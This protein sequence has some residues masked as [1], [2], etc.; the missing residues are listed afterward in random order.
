MYPVFVVAFVLAI[1]IGVY[2]LLSSLNLEEIPAKI[3]FIFI[4]IPLTSLVLYLLQ[5]ILSW[6]LI[7][8]NSNVQLRRPFGIKKNYTRQIEYAEIRQIG[9]L[10]GFRMNTELKIDV[11]SGKKYNVFLDGN[12][13]EISELLRFFE[14]SGVKVELYCNRRIK[15]KIELLNLKY[16]EN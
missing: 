15:K 6:E 4:G 12:I 13:K 8:T 9:F 16:H 10:Q 3:L 5:R 7:L 14:K 11:I 1:L 2:K